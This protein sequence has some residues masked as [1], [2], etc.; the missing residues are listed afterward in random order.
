[1]HPTVDLPQPEQYL[2]DPLTKP[3]PPHLPQI[4]ASTLWRLSILAI[5]YLQVS[6]R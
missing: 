1:V 4:A 3:T 2:M 5:N 6:E